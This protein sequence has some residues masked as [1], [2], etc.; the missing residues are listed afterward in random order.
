MYN[1]AKQLGQMYLTNPPTGFQSLPA[2]P[3]APH[4]L[5][6]N[7]HCP[8]AASQLAGQVLGHLTAP[9][10]TTYPWDGYIYHNQHCRPD[11]GSIIPCHTGNLIPYPTNQ[12]TLHG[13]GGGHVHAHSDWGHGQQRWRAMYTL[14]QKED[15]VTPEAGHVRLRLYLEPHQQQKQVEYI[16]GQTGNRSTNQASQEHPRSD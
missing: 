11:L 6:S 2:P 3:H 7:P 16:S 10:L 12:P 15:P 1:T 8:L 5:H 9:T 14:S 13:T 4:I